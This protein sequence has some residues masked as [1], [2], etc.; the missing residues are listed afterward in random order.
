M[1]KGERRR[2]RKALLFSGL[3]PKAVHARIARKIKQENRSEEEENQARFEASHSQAG[4]PGLGRKG[5]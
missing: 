3:S 2:L 4:S 1:T 5:S